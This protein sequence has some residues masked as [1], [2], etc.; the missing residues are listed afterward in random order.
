MDG[1]PTPSQFLIRVMWPIAR[2]CVKS[3]IPRC[4]RRRST[5]L[6]TGAL[7]PGYHICD[8]LGSLAWTVRMHSLSRDR[9]NWLLARE[10]RHR[11]DAVG[12]GNLSRGGLTGGWSRHR[13]GSPGRGSGWRAPS[14]RRAVGRG[15]HGS[16]G[17]TV[18]PPLPYQSPVYSQ[19]PRC[20]GVAERKAA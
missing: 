9:G 14:E 11:L 6:S 10:Y 13:G 18:T 16:G 3:W 1:S 5:R 7:V 19:S 12:C 17:V 8:R 2:P 20:I 15:Q 4:Q